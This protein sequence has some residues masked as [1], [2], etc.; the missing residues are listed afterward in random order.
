MDRFFRGNP[1]RKGK[2]WSMK[3]I[4]FALASL[5]NAVDKIKVIGGH[6]E[7]NAWNEPTIIIDPVAISGQMGSAMP[8]G[9]EIPGR[10]VYSTSGTPH[11]EQYTLTWNAATQQW[12]E[13]E[14]ATLIT[15]L[16]SHSSQHE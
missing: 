9:T 5:A 4:A 12:D 15:N 2:P 7:W 10:V 16:D 11:F 13:S 1:P 14:T 3:G 8:N 6:V